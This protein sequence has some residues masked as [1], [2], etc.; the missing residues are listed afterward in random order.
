MKRSIPGDVSIV[1]STPDL[2]HVNRPCACRSTDLDSF[3]S[4][5]EQGSKDLLVRG[6]NYI[7]EKNFNMIPVRFGFRSRSLPGALWFIISD[8]LCSPRAYH[9]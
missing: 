3:I 2:S 4:Q 8:F 9:P 6:I 7:E 5:R 1:V